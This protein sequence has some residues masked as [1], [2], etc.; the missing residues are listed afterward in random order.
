[1]LHNCNK[2]ENRVACPEYARNSREAEIPA[3]IPAAI[4]TPATFFCAPAQ[5]SRAAARI[6]G[7]RR[8]FGI[9]LDRA[10]IEIGFAARSVTFAGF[11]ANIETQRISFAHRRTRCNRKSNGRPSL[12]LSRFRATPGAGHRMIWRL[13]TRDLI[14]F[15]NGTP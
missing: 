3:E 15:E 5:G 1:M 10:V 11:R 8:L 6:L 2:V 13:L 4:Y 14:V 9:L 7:R 12:D